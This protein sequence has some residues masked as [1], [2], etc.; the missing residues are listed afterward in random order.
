MNIVASMEAGVSVLL[1]KIRKELDSDVRENA[2]LAYA[3]LIEYIK[4]KKEHIII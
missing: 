1:E 3:N 4:Y 2:E